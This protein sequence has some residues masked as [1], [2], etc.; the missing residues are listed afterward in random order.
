M[1]RRT[2][3]I[4]RRSRN[5]NTPPLRRRNSI[6]NNIVN[7]TSLIPSI[8]SNIIT[9]RPQRRLLKCRR[10][11]RVDLRLIAASRHAVLRHAVPRLVGRRHVPAAVGSDETPLMESDIRHRVTG[12]VS[13]EAI[14]TTISQRLNRMR[15]HHLVSE[16]IDEETTCTDATF[17]TIG[18]FKKYKRLTGS[19][20]PTKRTLTTTG[21]KHH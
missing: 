10:R 12:R 17:L 15:H 3:P 20:T 6:S 16:S 14:E 4:R 13:M 2:L 8:S 5:S 11:I 7:H 18:S 19:Y 1:R 21:A 9:R